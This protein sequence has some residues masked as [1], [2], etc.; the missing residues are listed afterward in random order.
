MSNIKDNINE[1]E[2]FLKN[3]SNVIYSIKTLSKRLNMRKKH[4]YYLFKKSENVVKCKPFDVGSN[5]SKL[6]IF[7]YCNQ[8]HIL[9]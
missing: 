6:N 2:E 8:N 5:K 3:S 4:I 1:L 9:N 7:K